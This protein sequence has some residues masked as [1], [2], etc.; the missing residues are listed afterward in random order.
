MKKGLTFLLFGCL[1]AVFSCSTD[2]DLYTEYK[3]IPIIYGMIDANADTNYVKITKAFCGSNDN[4]IDAFETALIYDSSN[5][6]EKLKAYIVEKR[7]A[8]GNHYEP[9]GRII[10]LDTIT[11]HNKDE[12]IF[13]APDQ[14]MYY[15]A[16][17]FN[18]NTENEKYKYRLIVVTPDGD[19]VSSETT[20]VGG[21]MA[22]ISARAN[23]Q[24]APSNEM[25]KLFFRSSEEAI[26]YDV[27]MQFNYWEERPGQARVK[28]KISWSYGTWPIS[29]YD[30]DYGGSIYYQEYSVNALFNRM[31][32]AIGGD[33]VVDAEH[34]HV[35]RYI[36]D[37]EVFLSGG[38]KELYE[39]YEMTQ[40]MGGGLVQTAY[41]N[42][43]GGFG[44]F[45]SRIKETRVCRLSPGT[46][47]DLLNKPWG[48][49][50]E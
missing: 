42:I 36:G 3:D 23:F 17:R 39:S 48:F 27:G 21:D 4:P 10:E 8:Y 37:F 47:Q 43:D 7:C 32:A 1:L 34:P 44:M 18:T 2:V 35:T 9:T 14:V 25:E 26:L 28:K 50:E 31:T 24:S 19:T 22:I 12:G 38:G 20:P 30:S 15:T 29:S 11:V 41:S 49:V 6:Q 13:Y 40:V 16:E 5:Y 45:S 33:T 46:I